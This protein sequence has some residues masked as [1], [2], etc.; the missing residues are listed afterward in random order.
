MHEKKYAVLC[1]RRMGRI[2]MLLLMLLG[3]TAA[4]HTTTQLVHAD[5]NDPTSL[6]DVAAHYSNAGM[7]WINSKDDYSGKSK[8]EHVI[9]PWQTTY[10][11]WNFFGPGKNSIL[12]DNNQGAK[13]ATY[14]ALEDTVEPQVSDAVKHAARFSYAMSQTGLDH[15][16]HGH[17]TFLNQAGRY[18]VGFITIILVYMSFIGSNLLHL[19]FKLFQ[20]V[21]PF[22]I[23]Q[24]VVGNNT[25][26]GNNIFGQLIKDLQ[27]LYHELSQLS[28]IFLLI[29]LFGGI[30]LAFL[31]FRQEGHQEG[32]GTNIALRIGKKFLQIMSIFIAPVIIGALS[33]QLTSELDGAMDVTSDIGLT[34]VYGNF[35]GFSDWAAHSRLALPNKNTMGGALKK[36]DQLNSNANNAFSEDYINAINAY[37]AGMSTPIN[38]ANP[39]YKTKL[40][41]VSAAVSFLTDYMHCANINGSAWN[42]TFKAR[43][44]KR[45]A[46]T[47]GDTLTAK[48]SS[49][50]SDK[51][52]SKK[53]ALKNPFK[54]ISN[55][56]YGDYGNSGNY[57]NAMNLQFYKDGSL[58]TYQPKGDKVFYFKSNAPQKADKSDV[59]AIGDPSEAGLS[60]IGLY[61]YLNID[62]S[63]G[64]KLNYTIPR[65]Y[66]SEND[67]NSHADVGFVGRG[68]LAIGSFCKMLVLIATSGLVVAFASA[69]IVKG[70]LADIPRLLLYVIKMSTGLGPAI[71]EVLR[72]MIDLYARIVV[73]EGIVYCFQGLLPEVCSSMESTLLGWFGNISPTSGA[74]LG[75][76]NLMPFASIGAEGI[77]VIRFLEA[78]AVGILIYSI[79]RCY[80]DVLRFI[81]S[82]I[83]NIM[84]SFK[85]TRL[86]HMLAATPQ[87]NSN[88]GV[89]A[90]NT[91]NASNNNNLNPAANFND[92]NAD[93]NEPVDD[94]PDT[95]DQLR[96]RQR[97]PEQN[98]GN[99]HLKFGQQMRAQG[100]LFALDALNNMD[101]SKTGRAVKRGAMAAAGALGGTKL[102][103]KLGLQNR[104]EG[105]QA[106]EKAEQRL[107]QAVAMA[108]D[109]LHANNTAKA[110]MS[111]A[112]RK[113]TSAQEKYARQMASTAA[114]DSAKKAKQNER[115]AKKA[116]MDQFKPAGIDE[117]G[118]QKAELKD[119]AKTVD[120][121]DAL[122]AQ[123]AMAPEAKAANKQFQ[124]KAQKQYDQAQ[125]RTEKLR[126]EA[127]KAQAEYEKNPSALNK[128]KLAHAHNRLKAAE[129]V[130]DP[131]KRAL[132]EHAYKKA[133][134]PNGYGLKA[135]TKAQTET[136]KARRFTALTGKDAATS[137]KATA[138]QI[139]QA[140]K[141]AIK[142]KQVLLDPKATQAQKVQATQILKAANVV[143]ETGRQFGPYMTQAAGSKLRNASSQAMQNAKQYEGIDQA[144]IATN[145]VATDN[146][147]KLSPAES[148][149]VKK[150]DNAR[151]VL[152]TGQI[153]AHGHPRLANKREIAL[154]QRTLNSDPAKQVDR[155]Q[156]RMLSATSTVMEQARAYGKQKVAQAGQDLG[157]TELNNVQQQA[158]VEYMQK[159]ETQAQ[160]RASGMVNTKN[161]QA[162]QKQIAQIQQM[163][164]NMRQGLNAS[165][166]PI[167][168]Q[169]RK[170][171]EQP[172]QGMLKRAGEQ[173]F[174]RLYASSRLVDRSHYQTTTNKQVRLATQRLLNAYNTKDTDQIRDAREKAAAIGMANPIINSQK[175][176]QQTVHT[177]R[178]QRNNVV[179]NTVYQLGSNSDTFADIQEAMAGYAEA[180]AQV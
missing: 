19:V 24:N 95:G 177:M 139:A 66:V 3:L 165:L 86:G 38:I 79:M 22:Y 100:G 75:S 20:W 91:N 64:N 71:L 138:S 36:A 172:S 65:K 159:P 73:G 108:T 2:L 92:P 132:M 77:G 40:S 81:D 150:L 26:P 157:P 148:T 78:I 4:F 169:L 134:M 9:T 158:I 161:P 6:A 34:E 143:T 1:R 147:P 28:I 154:A 144:T 110:G 129:T 8:T 107:K 13:E 164:Q 46:N 178:E 35:V 140:Q 76:I 102:G 16:M 99:G 39:T 117:Q 47:S 90:D 68:L 93:P 125:E 10:G 27:P 41:D 128:E 37:G 44:H 105:M 51:T 70:V 42:A 14:S 103:R 123:N 17:M 171:D 33:A 72:E 167:R 104:G 116:I 115:K 5:D 130:S 109:P 31:G 48:G 137:T 111:E 98:Y 55:D 88:L 135:A 53:D 174:D 170:S 85:R 69:M 166:D 58:D 121:I 163:D 152:N 50:G 7:S 126:Q 149:Y 106:P 62:G 142:A 179:N 160:L 168:R 29:S 54:A 156:A 141:D 119:A 173:Q 61:N 11:S 80:H 18:I 87:P 122:K 151:Q 146:A 175:K 89:N 145:M 15:P 52:I 131:G 133:V 49:S 12:S 180:K 67:L 114:I 153:M 155:I 25:N 32:L 162:L 127:E 56:I 84:E 113:A 112:Q 94:T 118:R 96:N 120:V 63:S 82:L 176:L 57:D 74:V 83:N 59:A 43:L 60:S 124:D 21:N 97:D 30:T 45:I 136:A 23:L 101:K